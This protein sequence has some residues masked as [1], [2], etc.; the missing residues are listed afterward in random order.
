[1]GF[2]TCLTLIAEVGIIEVQE[3]KKMPVFKND[4]EFNEFLEFLAELSV[5]GETFEIALSALK[6][7]TALKGF[8]GN[9][10]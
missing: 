4:L 2:S 8:Y 7:Q 9:P 10:Y 6:L 5:N 1:V 3:E